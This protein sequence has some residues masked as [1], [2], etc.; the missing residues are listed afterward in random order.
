V[1]LVAASV[2]CG[3]QAWRSYSRTRSPSA[4]AERYFTD[5]SGGDAAAALVLAE[6]LPP[7]SQ[8][9]YL[10]AEVLR[11]QLA[12]ASISSIRAE[13]EQ[14]TGDRAEVG[15]R[16]TLRFRSASVTKLDH[17]DLLRHGH[18]W[19]I[20]TIA[21][22]ITV[23]P[24]ASG[25]DRLSL[26][27]RPVPGGAVTLFPGAVPLVSDAPAVIV[28]GTPSVSLS[29]T[30]Q[31][32]DAVAE[33]SPQAI[34]TVRSA[35][36]SALVKCTAT[37]HNDAHCPLPDKGRPVPGTLHATIPARV[38]AD[39]NSIGLST[40]GG[41]IDIDTQVN[42]NGDWQVWDFDNI[43]RPMSGPAQLVV[44]AEASVDAPSAISWVAPDGS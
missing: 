19:R 24:A 7:P 11:K 39:S 25:A 32:A 42:V 10:T 16:Y 2:V 20:V 37:T 9:R 6:D 17:V 33:L 5:L 13:S 27:G 23:A 15:V 4:V 31:T 44:H 21:A 8:R 30:D 35:L 26:A 18:D 40:I 14:R 1:L 3:F 22:P 43:E 38:A 41:L 28:G 36:R 29:D 12:V 34:A